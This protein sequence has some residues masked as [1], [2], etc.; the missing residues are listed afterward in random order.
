MIGTPKG[1]AVAQTD[2]AVVG[3]W[4]EYPN[5]QK[6]KTC[7]GL[8]C[9]PLSKWTKTRACG[10]GENMVFK[11]RM[12]MNKVLLIGRLTRDP[13]VR[14]GGENKDK[15]VARYTLAVDRRY[16][17]DGDDSAD[18]INCTA[19]GKGAEFAEKY[20]HKGIKI[21]I[22]GRIQTGSYT[23][24]DGNKVYTTDVIVDEHEF[25]ES[26]GAAGG[27]PDPNE[28]GFVPVGDDIDEELPFN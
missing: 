26:K 16:K 12:R 25:A 20:L 23:N 8:P 19:F 11:R 21:A 1:S 7:T 17:K 6:C 13:E 2:R 22:I 5:K 14:Y 15:A 10:M 28:G 24:K 9:L 3:G 27:T 4:G 18:F